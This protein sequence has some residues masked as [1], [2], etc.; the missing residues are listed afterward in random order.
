MAENSGAPRTGV[1]VLRSDDPLGACADAV[2][3]AIIDV[4]RKRGRT[5]LVIPGGSALACVGPARRAVGKEVWSRVALTW[6][7]ERCVRFEDPE[8]SRGAAY[9]MGHLDRRQ[10]PGDELPLFEDGDADPAAAV[11]RVKEDFRLLPFSGAVDVALLGLGPDGHVASLFPGHA[12]LKSRAAVIHVPDAPKPPAD[13]ITLSAPILRAA[14][15]LVFA[16]GAD[17]R[18]VVDEIERGVS[19][20]PLMKMGHVRLFTDGSTG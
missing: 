5:R 1:E 12:A 3:R 14:T 17:K 9:R 2:A 20:S 15:V 6:S 13:R 8:S 16:R 4:D 11:A 18:Q 7:D 10:P 19:K